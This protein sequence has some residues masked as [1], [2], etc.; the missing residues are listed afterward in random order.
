MR[1]EGADQIIQALDARP[2]ARW[3]ALLSQASYKASYAFLY[4]TGRITWVFGAF[5]YL[6]ERKAFVR[7]PISAHFETAEGFQFALAAVHSN[8]AKLVA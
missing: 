2:G 3:D 6:D 7:E 8:Y 4:S 1:V 5:V